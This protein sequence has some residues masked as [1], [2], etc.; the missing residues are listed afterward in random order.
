MLLEKLGMIDDGHGFVY[1]MFFRF[2]RLFQKK[3]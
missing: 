2:S 1:I 3:T